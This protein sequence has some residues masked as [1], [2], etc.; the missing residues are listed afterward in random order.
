MSFR[1]EK[2]FCLN[3]NNL[4]EVKNDLLSLGMKNLYPKR[5][6]N[7]IYFD[8][9]NYIFCKDSED[10]ILPRKKVRV[11]WYNDEYSFFKEV[12]LSSIEGRFKYIDKMQDINSIDN[13]LQTSFFDYAYGSISPSLL[14]TYER[15]YY[16]L[17]FMRITFDKNI[18]YQNLRSNIKLNIS[19]D[20]NVM[21]IKTSINCEDDYINQFVSNPVVR[22]SKYCRG[23]NFHKHRN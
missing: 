9:Y 22:F 13:L 7:S 14:V 4:Y 16:S 2:K 3:N 21:E 19:D 6:I 17:Q 10:G 1:K 11:R 20:F 8:S 12:K 23:L 15:E 5:T 18:S